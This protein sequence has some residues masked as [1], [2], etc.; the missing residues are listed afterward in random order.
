MFLIGVKKKIAVYDYNL[1]IKG[2]S[3]VSLKKKKQMLIK[4]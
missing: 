2:L 1:F 3:K 4:C